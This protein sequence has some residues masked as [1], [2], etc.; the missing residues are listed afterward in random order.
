MDRPSPEAAGPPQPARRALGEEIEADGC[1]ALL[2]IASSSNDPDLAPFVGEAHLGESFL[3]ARAADQDPPYLGLLTAME[4]QEAAATGC[5]VLSP[6]ALGLA[7]LIE[8][9]VSRAELW[10]ELLRR[11]LEA[12][13]VGQGRVAVAGRPGAGVLLAA[14]RSLGEAGWDLVDGS[15][16]VRRL[17]KGKTRGELAES[18]RVA[19]A[20]V[21][22]FERVAELLA[23]A[24]SRDGEL[25]LGEERLTA[26][27]LRAE[28]A[29][30]LARHEL[31]QPEGNIIA[32]GAD[33]AVPHT[34]GGGDRVLRPGESVIVD[35]FP[36]GRL[37]A[38]CTRTFCVGEPPVA[39]AVAHATVF[40]VLE[41]AYRQAGAGVAGWD[42]QRRACDAFEKAGYSTV[43]GD[44]ETVRGYVHGLGHGVGYE[45]H[46]LPGFHRA[47][48]G[49]PDGRLEVGDLFTLEPG[50]YDPEGGWGVRLEDLCHLGPAGLE[51]LTPVSYALDPRAWRG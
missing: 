44:P 45:L 47:A 36:R 49:K 8:R 1:R 51:S 23:A 12:A 16:L 27:R 30:A 41:A 25:W 39:L 10:G 3:V 21:T 48:S 35:L 26:G 19:A 32:A 2:V 5:R 14:A 42:L 20:T 46:E 6:A 33:S 9:G 18:R 15:S 11:G 43:A 4:R 24:G 17:R 28:V 29:G 38:D 22:A 31:E 34:R 40:E 7:E 50:L 13:A 37:F